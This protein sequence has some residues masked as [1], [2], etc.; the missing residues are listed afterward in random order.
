MLFSINADCRGKKD[1]RVSWCAV[2]RRRCLL[3]LNVSV[4]EFPSTSTGCIH[5]GKT[6]LSRTSLWYIHISDLPCAGTHEVQPY[7]EGHGGDGWQQAQREP[8]ACPGSPEGKPLPPAAHQTQHG[9]KANRGDYAFQW[10]LCMCVWEI[11][12]THT[13]T[14]TH[15]HSHT[16]SHTHTRSRARVYD[17]YQNSF[18]T[19]TS[20]Y[21]FLK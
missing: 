1:W 20:I 10:F 3:V 14:Y 16:L 6:A 9:Q 21:L 12:H 17:T 4:K 5:K 7:R 19:C 13:Y 15:T 8:A 2:G 11:V 18:P